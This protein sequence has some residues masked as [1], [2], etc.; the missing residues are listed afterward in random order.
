MKWNIIN[1]DTLES[2]NTT[3]L[4][5]PVYSIIRAASQTAGKGRFGRT[6]ESPK[7]NLYASFIL[8]DLGNKSALVSFII[9]LSAGQM[10][11]QITTGISLK[12]PNDI[13]LNGKKIAGILLEKAENKLIVGIGINLISHPQHTVLYPTTSLKTTFDATEVL[14]KLIDAFD[15]N[16]LLYN[17]QG[18]TPIQKAWKEM[19][20][21]IGTPIEVRLPTQTL[22]G[23]FTDL[24]ETGALLLKT[25]TG[26][27]PVLAGDVFFTQQKESN[28]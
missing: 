12:W 15:K 28:D 14:H 7:G 21:G 19:A 23:I 25:P 2:T 11:S 3:A 22:A 5:Y 26:I 4:S 10:L 27:I 13:L 1:F 16:L 17:Q 9:A 6:W 8:P 20:T 24:D 18:F